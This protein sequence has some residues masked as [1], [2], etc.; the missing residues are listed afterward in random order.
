MFSDIKIF[1]DDKEINY[2]YEINGE[3]IICSLNGNDTFKN[4]D[5]YFDENIF[6]NIIFEQEIKFRKI[7]KYMIRVDFDNIQDQLFVFKVKVNYKFFIKSIF[8]FINNFI[9]VDT[10][11]KELDIFKNLIID[12]FNKEQIDLLINEIEKNNDLVLNEDYLKKDKI[13]NILL[14]N[15][16]YLSLV[17]KMTYTDLMLLI[18]SYISCSK[19]P[20][21]DQEIFNNLVDAAI[22]YNWENPFE[23]VWRLAMSYDSK[24]LNF[25]LLDNFFVNSKNCYYLSEYIHG[26]SQVNQEK[27]VNMIVETKDEE[28]IEQFLNEYFEEIDLEDKYKSILINAINN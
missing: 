9:D 18:T 2:M 25:D 28:F 6:E 20:K 21:I 3:E 10:L 27:I 14:N 24:G 8:K 22:I 26:V 23:K 1:L 17:N 5:I 7:K 11:L 19:S 16:F 15:E 4:L 13:N 12:K